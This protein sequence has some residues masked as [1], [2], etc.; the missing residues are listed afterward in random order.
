MWQTSRFGPHPSESFSGPPSP[1]GS[2]C[3]R[4]GI[5]RFGRFRI[6]RNLREVVCARRLRAGYSPL[7][8]AHHDIETPGVVTLL[9]PGIDARLDRLGRRLED[10]ACKLDRLL[11]QEELMAAA[12]SSEAQALDAALTALQTEVAGLDA[13]IHAEALPALEAIP[14]LLK[15]FNPVTIEQVNAVTAVAEHVKTVTAALAGAAGPA[16][17]AEAGATAPPVEPPVEPPP[18]TNAP[19]VPTQAVYTFD[20]SAGVQPDPRFSD[21]GF[22]E[23]EGGGALL[24][25][26]EDTATEGGKGAVVPGYAV[27]TGEVVRAG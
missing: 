2:L 21:S 26:S 23:K 11:R 4:S 8:M 27:F 19:D 10:I 5:Y 13:E 22:V 16:R 17:E 12:D 15:Q 18:A 6:A 20:S 24:Y 9:L 7:L 14:E 3:V 25:F 1:G